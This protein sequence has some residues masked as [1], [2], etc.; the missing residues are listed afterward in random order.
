MCGTYI[1]CFICTAHLTSLSSHPTPKVGAI[2]PQWD[3]LFGKSVK[4]AELP[5]YVK[6]GDAGFDLVAAEDTIIWP[7]QT[8]VVQMGLALEIPPGYEL[9]VRPQWYDA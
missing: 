9:Q 2:A 6:S 3:F 4:D 5:R 1:R 8:K 7:G